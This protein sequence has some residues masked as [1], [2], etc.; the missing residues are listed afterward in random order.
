MPLWWRALP[1]CLSMKENA[2]ARELK[3]RPGGTVAGCKL[4]SINN[5]DNHRSE[6]VFISF[7]KVMLYAFL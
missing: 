5:K 6:F 2:L 1:R 3:A 4:H 7:V